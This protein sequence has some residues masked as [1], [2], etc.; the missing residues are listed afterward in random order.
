[1]QPRMRGLSSNM[2]VCAL[3]LC[4]HVV[5]GCHES[6]M[7]HD[8]GSPRN[9][10][11]HCAPALVSMSLISAFSHSCRGVRPSKSCQQQVMYSNTHG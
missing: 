9:I 3:V 5:I 2:G 8:D 7:R 11:H 10:N 4:M 1:M 6:M